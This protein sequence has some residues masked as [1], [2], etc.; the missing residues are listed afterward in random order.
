MEDETL[1]RGSARNC[2]QSCRGGPIAT[3]TGLPKDIT[4]KDP[5][6]GS[7]SGFDNPD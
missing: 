5:A 6:W 7:G 4:T 3:I 1:R 2:V